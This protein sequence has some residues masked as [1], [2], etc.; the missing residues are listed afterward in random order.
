MSSKSQPADDRMAEAAGAEESLIQ[1]RRQKAERLRARG[2]NPFANDVATDGRALIATIRGEAALGLVS[3]AADQRFDAEKIQ[4]L[5]GERAFVVLGR[6]IA[7]R[8]FGKV[9]FLRVRDGSG[10]LQLFV[11]DEVLGD[12]FRYSRN[13][14]LRTSSRRR[15]R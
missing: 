3:S 9:V 11:K 15:A 6:L 5:F 12:A 1:S 10:E 8:G 13:S 2:E 7:R 14:I 4:A